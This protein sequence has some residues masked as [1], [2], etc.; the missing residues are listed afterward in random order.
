MEDRE[1]ALQASYDILT[2]AIGFLNWTKCDGSSALR[3]GRAIQFLETLQSNTRKELWEVRG[4]QVEA[5]MK[6]ME[7]EQAHRKG[8]ADEQESST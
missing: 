2:D 8:A 4:P 1:K 3:L 7:A 6:R 5:E